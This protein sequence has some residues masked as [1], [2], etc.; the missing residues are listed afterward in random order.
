M[1]RQSSYEARGKILEAAL[2][3]FGDKGYKE[4][5]VREIARI[6]G[7]AVGGLYP[8]FGSKEQLYVEV[9]REEMKRYNDRNREFENADPQVGIRR[10]IENHLEYMASRKEIIARHFKDYDLGFVK[11]VAS[12]FFAYQKEFLEATIRKG[13]E[14]KIFPV[15]DCG[16]AALF[17]LCLL[18]GALFYD[19]AGMIDLTRLGDT[20]CRLVLSFLR[21][22]ETTGESH[23]RT[24][25]ETGVTGYSW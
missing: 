17:V 18:K 14:R 24:P 2:Q 5:T 4:A 21:N 20:L 8:Y 15:A 1:T 11:P 12:Q 16:E 7:V 10:Y 25:G 9:L 23:R 3:V 19:L 22:E 13:A 6:A